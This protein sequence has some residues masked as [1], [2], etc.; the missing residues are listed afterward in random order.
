MFDSATRWGSNPCTE[1]TRVYPSFYDSKAPDNQRIL[2]S[3]CQIK[4]ENK[5]TKY[6]QNKIKYYLTNVQISS[7]MKEIYVKEFIWQKEKVQHTM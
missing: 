5:T 7:I 2:H 3:I 6:Y 4:Y 1:S